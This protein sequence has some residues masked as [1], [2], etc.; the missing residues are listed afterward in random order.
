MGKYY[1]GEKGKNQKSKIKILIR[2]ARINDL[3]TKKDSKCLCMFVYFG[4]ATLRNLLKTNNDD[5]D[6]ND[7]RK[8]KCFDLMIPD[9]HHYQYKIYFR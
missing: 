3:Y 2:F 8:K 1:K 5:D 7:Q 6:D 9:H 4:N